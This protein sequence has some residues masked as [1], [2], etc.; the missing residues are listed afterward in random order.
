MTRAVHIRLGYHRDDQRYGRIRDTKAET[1]NN[2][3]VLRFGLFGG[4]LAHLSNKTSSLSLKFAIED[5][6]LYTL[7]PIS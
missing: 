6:G 5:L 4:Q 7:G 3:N 1:A 2:A